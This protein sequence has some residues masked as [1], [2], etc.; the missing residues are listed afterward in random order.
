MA[1][2]ALRVVMVPRGAGFSS[3]PGPA[4]AVTV[5]RLGDTNLSLF[6]TAGTTTLM[7]AVGIGLAAAGPPF[8]L[9]DTTDGGGLL[10]T[11][12]VV[13]VRTVVLL[14]RIGGPVDCL[15]TER[16]LRI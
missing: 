1:L 6:T 13:F 16:V 10:F 9:A 14:V 2:V 15:L 3:E 5:W 4:V 7:L 8:W 12:V 11:E